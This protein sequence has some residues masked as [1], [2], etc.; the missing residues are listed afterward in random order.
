MHIEVLRSHLTND[1]G[2]FENI[3][4]VL[5]ALDLVE[6]FIPKISFSPMQQLKGNL[7]LNL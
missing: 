2:K 6:N 1:A 5:H 4:A 3:I 7:R